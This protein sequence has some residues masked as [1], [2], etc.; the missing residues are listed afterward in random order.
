MLGY[1]NESKRYRL[2][3]PI[4]KKLIK[5]S[6]VKFTG[7]FDENNESVEIEQINYEGLHI[8][9]D[10]FN[11]KANNNKLGEI[12]VHENVNVDNINNSRVE[13]QKN[14]STSTMKSFLK[15]LRLPK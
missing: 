7:K 14:K 3:N 8:Y 13:H 1:S 12:V 2:K 5:S 4:D 15:P 10:L 6:D 11:E 9:Y